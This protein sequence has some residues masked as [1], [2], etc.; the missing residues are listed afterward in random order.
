MNIVVSGCAGFIGAK[1][2]DLLLERGD[3]VFGL[4]NMSD[5]YDVRLKHHRLSTLSAMDG[6]RFFRC[7]ISDNAALVSV[8]EEIKASCGDGG[9][10][11]VINL[12]ARAGVRQS[13]ENPWIYY[14]TNV[15]GTL[16]L[17]EFCRR[18]EIHKFVLASTSSVYGESETPFREDMKTDL[19]ISQYA[20]SKKSAEGLCSVYNSLYGMDISVLRYFT[21]YGPAGRPDM[22]VFRFIKWINEGEEISILGDGEQKRDFTYVDDIASGTVLATINLGFEIINLGSSV[23]VSLNEIIGMIEQGVGRKA[24]ITCGAP[25]PSDIRSTLADIDKAKRI[26]DWKPSFDTQKGIENSLEWYNANETFVRS[27]E[28]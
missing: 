5:A 22:S 16:N 17:L 6:F 1:V 28:V 8:C 25:H 18:E 19:Q 12:A 24:R 2:S 20:S 3:C 21:V 14:S 4:D 27:I 10:N 23:S 15:M 13:I 7:D 9:I 26:L 11:C